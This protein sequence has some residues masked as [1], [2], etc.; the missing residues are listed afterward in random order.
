MKRLLLLALFATPLTA[1]TTATTT[2]ARTSMLVWVPRT[3]RS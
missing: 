3:R 1:Q 2:S